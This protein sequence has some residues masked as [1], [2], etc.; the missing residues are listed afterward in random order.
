[1]E[2]EGLTISTQSMWDQEEALASL[3]EPSYLA[4]LQYILG[5]DVI[6]ADETHWRLMQPGA[7]KKWWAWCRGGT[8]RGRRRRGCRSR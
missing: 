4:L 6:G 3:L 1:M 5:A 7:S 8:P 2:R